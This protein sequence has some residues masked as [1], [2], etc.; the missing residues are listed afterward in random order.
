MEV[1]DIDVMIMTE[2]KTWNVKLEPRLLKKFFIS[3]ATGPTPRGGVVT[4]INRYTAENI[5][6]MSRIGATWT[7]DE[8]TIKQ[9]GS[10]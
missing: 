10:G 2:V 5:K 4:I 6:A 1:E 9:K 7:E 3:K 8:I